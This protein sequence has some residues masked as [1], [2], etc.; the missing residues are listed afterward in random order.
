MSEFFADLMNVLMSLFDG[1]CA[2]FLFR[3]LAAPRFPSAK[4]TVGV[5]WA[6]CSIA[7][8][9]GFS[10]ASELTLLLKFAICAF[11]LMAFSVCW[12]KGSFLQ[13]V[14]PAVLFV[15]V[16]ELSVQAANCLTFVNGLIMD[17]L[18]RLAAE[19]IISYESL[20]PLAYTLTW[21][22]LVFIGVLRSLL[23]Y[24]T[25]R[26]ITKSCR[27]RLNFDREAAICLLPA[28][29][30]ILVCA[31]L[32]LILITVN[33]GYTDLL[34]NRYPALYLLIPAVSLTLLAAIVFTFRLYQNMT[35]LQRERADRAV[36]ENQLAQAI[37]SVEETQRLYENVR[38]V[39]HDM[40]N[41]MAVLQG[42]LQRKNVCD[43][44]IGQYFENMSLSV[45]RLDSGIS[46]GN[47][48]SDAI[49]GGKFRLAR[50]EISG[51][52]LDA[53]EFFFNGDFAPYDIGIILNNGLDNAIEACRAE[54][55]PFITVRSFQ[56]KKFYFIE[57]ENSFTGTLKLDAESGL[58]LSGKKDPE[59]HGIGLRNIRNCAKKYSGEIE[60][61]A[62]NQKFTLSVMLQ[63]SVKREEI[64]KD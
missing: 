29:V 4:Y 23:I 56:K 16:R 40:K 18:V 60:C 6:G 12:Y 36:L 58:P 31:M 62:E 63:A 24:K 51:I 15:A 28:A 43:G 46:T 52:R 32:R 22:M 59:L 1:W 30:G 8:Y 37:A 19:E 47:A 13:R 27:F 21:T 44:E 49:I 41:H 9:F 10:D 11:G 2:A 17:L 7:C 45:E 42:L 20:T 5:F 55:D 26:L 25:V 48:V 3:G 54:S 53:E 57:I 61:I 14:S 39:R 38:A 35:A 33:N 64:R 50:R 34:Y